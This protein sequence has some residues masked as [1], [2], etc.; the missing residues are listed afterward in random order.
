M[1]DTFYTSVSRF[2]NDILVRGYRDGNRYSERVRFSPTL[3][4]PAEGGDWKSLTGRP[5]KPI[6]FDSM[7]EAR[8]FIQQYG[9]TSNFEIHGNTNYLA[10]YV[11]EKFPGTIEFN[12][13]IINVTTIDIEVA[14]DDGFPEPQQ[15]DHPV[16]TITLKNNIDN[17]LL[18]LG[19]RRLRYF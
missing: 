18:C 7:R 14:S 16:I 4:V 11:Q 10:Q 9:D 13:D 3:Y 17:I 8:E 6:E 5:L 1:N 12:R 2:G 19:V 15:A